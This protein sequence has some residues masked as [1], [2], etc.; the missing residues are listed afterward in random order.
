MLGGGVDAI[1]KTDLWLIDSFLG[2]EESLLVVIWIVRKLLA[3]K[4]N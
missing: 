2:V 1:G 4:S 3:L